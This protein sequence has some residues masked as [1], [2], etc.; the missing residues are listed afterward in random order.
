MP[1]QADQSINVIRMVLLAVLT[2]ALAFRDAAAAESVLT[3]VWPAALIVAWLY[4]MIVQA[5]VWRGW[6]TRSLPWLTMLADLGFIG[7]GIG[8]EL[9]HVSHSA[10]EVAATLSWGYALL[11]LVIL[12][13]ALR[14]QP[15]LTLL[16]GVVAAML[17]ASLLGLNFPFEPFTGFWSD[18]LFRV[19][20]LVL[21]GLF[22]SFHARSVRMRRETDARLKV[23]ATQSPSVLF[24]A[25]VAH[26]EFHLRYVSEGSGVLLGVEP[27][28]LVARPQ[29]FFTR[30][31]LGWRDLL[32]ELNEPRRSWS[33][34]FPYR[35]SGRDL[36]L[37]A[38]AT[39]HR[40][41]QGVLVFSGVVTDATEQRHTAEVLREANQSKTDF[42]AAMSHELRTPLNAIL[43]NADLLS[44]LAVTPDDE[45][46]FRD[47]K[48]SGETLLGLIEDILVFSRL[49]AGRLTAETRAFRWKPQLEAVVDAFRP[50]AAAKRLTL[51]ARFPETPVWIETDALRL[52]QIVSNLL[53]NAVKFT[54]SGS[55][56][57]DV[58]FETG[59]STWLVVR[60]SDTGIGIADEL[61][62]KIFD[63]FTQGEQGKSR[64]YGGLGLGLSISRSL[65][66]LLGGT[67]GVAS[68]PGAGS[69]FTLRLPVKTGDAPL[70]AI[71]GP[72]L[73]SR[74][75]VRILVV[76][77]NLT[78]QDVETRMLTKLGGAVDV[79]ASGFEA[80][81]LASKQFYDLIFMDWQMPG[82]DGRETTARIRK[83]P[84]GQDLV[85]VA[86][87]GHALPG[88]RELL[89][90]SGFDDYLS[91]PVR[92][93]DFRAVLTKWVRA[94]A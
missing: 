88:D 62:D 39:V 8:L 57:V 51:N 29:L 22:S 3:A 67:V 30:I 32:G 26:G 15:W 34:E 46:A 63:K 72:P 18:Q 48:M 12:F 78:N 24:Q 16:N 70:D 7:A 43:G 54:P 80:V 92:M 47:L 66:G 75:E 90:A 31:G 25:E 76:E 85:I 10:A 6:L 93:D 37:R 38:T 19:V 55:V 33:A 4:A 9:G 73:E 83:L 52:R 56:T 53:G 84:G 81:E 20:F 14:E 21:A 23:L 69:V 68:Q 59:D 11:F 65:A 1:S 60:V 91:K 49:E 27:H 44:R 87:S 77:D 40:D 17:Y 36:W 45:K 28:D 82:M 2:L 58:F 94:P 64:T 5:A 61:H 89:L 79:A 86:L 35:G 13:S 50:Q 74:R 71:A 41:A 42:L